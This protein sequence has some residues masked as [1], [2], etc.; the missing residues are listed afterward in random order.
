MVTLDTLARC[1]AGMDENSAMDTGRMLDSLAQVRDATGPT[2]V[3]GVV[4]HTGKSDRQTA[5]GSSALESGVDTVYRTEGD[6]RAMTLT[7]T[8]RKDGPDTDRLALGFKAITGTGSGVAVTHLD[9][10]TTAGLPGVDEVVT[11][12]LGTLHGGLTAAEVTRQLLGTKRPS[13]AA[14]QQT[15]RRLDAAVGAGAIG[16]SPPSAPGMA[17]VYHHAPDGGSR[18]QDH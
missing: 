16:Y 11:V 6:A 4:H 1:S 9:R 17:G 2:G 15:R 14:V 13:N 10:V 18:D 5:R 7:C 3:V 12:V 8:K